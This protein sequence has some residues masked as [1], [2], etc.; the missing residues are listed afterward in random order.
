MLNFTISA[1]TTRQPGLNGAR[2][3]YER[4]FGAIPEWLEDLSGGRV[5]SLLRQ[6]LGRGVP[7]IAAEVLPD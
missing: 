2:Q 6:A 5:L 7:L 4:R 1:A 3:D